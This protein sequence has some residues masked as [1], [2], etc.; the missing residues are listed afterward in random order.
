MKV[1][2]I[3]P[4]SYIG[5]VSVHILRL[6]EL[7]KNNTDIFDI[8]FIDESPLPVA[9]KG[10]INIRRVSDF[11]KFIKLIKH[12]DIIHIHSV[13]W[14]IRIFN[15]LFVI[16][17]HKPFIVTLHSFRI[18]GIRKF[19]TFIL[20]KKAERVISVNEEIKTIL[21]QKN[22]Q[23]EIKEAF[24]PPIISDESHLPNDI[25]EKIENEK[26]SKTLICANAFRLTHYNGG[27]LYGLDQCIE[28]AVKLKQEKLDI[29]I[30]F[31]IG[32]IRKSEPLYTT[33]KW[34]VENLGLERYIWI[35]PYAISFVKLISHC[36]MILRPTLSDGDALTIREA[37]YF[38]KIVI[39]SDVVN[40]PYGTILYK[41]GSV[42][43][44]FEKIVYCT[45]L[46]IN[47]NKNLI[48]DPLTYFNFYKN[49][50]L[51]NVSTHTETI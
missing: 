22:V 43:D 25:E 47:P 26:K 49:L 21:S 24:I 14:L 51:T 29:V 19:I 38:N 35:I 40:R 44:L 8:E 1:L 30:I 15:I 7:L 36:S 20:L 31:V 13:H 33:L 28:V 12:S 18:V 32:N 16:L 27:E 11:Y 42:S 48:D 23:S 9:K 3:G 37:L 2:Q 50:Y 10:K 6:S 39:A 4:I 17:L 34:K 41:T 45:S 5:G 46:K